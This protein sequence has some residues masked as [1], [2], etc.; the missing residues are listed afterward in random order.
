LLNDA[1]FKRYEMAVVISNDSDL[2]EPIKI[3][4]EQLNLDVGILNPNKRSPSI[5]LR[6]AAKFF[7]PIRDGVL[8]ASQFPASLTDKNGT[9][10]KPAK[11]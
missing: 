4:Q 2:L 7:I 8:N 3:V 1:H 11:W 6:R 5:V 9:F 10:T